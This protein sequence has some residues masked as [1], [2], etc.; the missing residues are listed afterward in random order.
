[1]SS[2]RR[3]TPSGAVSS[4][5]SGATAASTAAA[6]ATANS[7]ESG[8][9]NAP[10]SASF[11]AA[12]R[13]LLSGTKP[14]LNGQ[15]LI[16]SG[17]AELDA[18][19]GGGLL[20]GT[21]VLLETPRHDAGAASLALVDDM[22]RYFAAEGI[23]SRQCAV[24]VA[25]DAS[26]FAEHQ[27]P[28]ELSVAQKQVKQQ[29]NAMDIAKGN[30]KDANSAEGDTSLT[31]AWQYGKYLADA[32][33]QQ[34]QRFCHSFDLSRPIHKEL[35]EANPP[36]CVDALETFFHAQTSGAST[37][38]CN[39][40]YDQVLQ[41]IVTEIQQR[42]SPA[43]GNEAQ[44]VRVCMR[45]LGSPLLGAPDT[46]HMRA[47][48]AFVR[49]LRALISGRPVVCVL[50]GALATFPVDFGHEIRHLCDY[51]LEFKSF[52]GE[53]DMLPAELQE[54]HGLMDICKLARVHSL[55]CHSV[56]AMKYGV[57]RERR[58]L[59]IEKFHLP[60]EGSRSSSNNNDAPTSSGSK[61]SSLVGSSSFK[62][63]STHV[64]SSSCGSGG[65]S[66]SAF[67]PLAF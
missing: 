5:R 29:L 47:V 13:R 24:L 19:L 48:F 2:F 38:Q 20:L 12:P 8:L 65:A 39:A 31:I 26:G 22:H 58:K 6:T 42:S 1:M 60:P 18:I 46:A 50:S 52:M 67:D 56:D 30:S 17:H 14:F 9:H 66:P 25:E 44:V 34:Q 53:Q 41:R 62:K 49:K 21:I 27:L 4:A 59:K 23:V 64:H 16:S 3:K 54:F 63:S 28:L 55:A 40:V 37:S 36:V 35:L 33:N 10:R 51:V 15:T 32:S 57:K 61:T 43:N 7:A 45:E 11:A